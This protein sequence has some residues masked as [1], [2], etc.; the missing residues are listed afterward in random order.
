[1]E[2]IKQQTDISLQ[3]VPLT[4]VE[5]SSKNFKK[6]FFLSAYL[7]AIPLF[8]LFLVLFSLS[9]KYQSNGYVSRQ[10]HQPQFQALPGETTTSAVEVETTDA[11]IKALENFFGQY[12]SPLKGHARMIVEEADKNNIDYRLLP[13]IAMQESTL[14]KRIIKNS[15]NCWGFG[16]YGKKVT[17]FENYEQAI[18][19]ISSTLSKKYIQKGYTNPEEIVQK[20][21][22]SDTG[23]WPAVVNLI[24]QKLTES[25]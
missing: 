18:K 3:E 14:C 17:R 24:M 10:A 20:Y 6:I 19:V 8:L 1:M 12:D 23:K 15:Y 22:P 9:I 7:G 5:P 21:T 4:V 11:R 25:L 2:N 13:G 16:I